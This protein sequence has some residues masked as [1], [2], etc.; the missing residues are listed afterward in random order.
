MKA[1]RKAH[2]REVAP[3]GR[4]RGCLAR[5]PSRRLSRQACWFLCASPVRT[6][7]ASPVPTSVG[8]DGVERSRVASRSAAASAKEF[9]ACFLSGD[10]VHS[11]CDSCGRGT[12]RARHASG[13][14]VPREG[15]Q[16][17]S[18]AG[19]GRM[20]RASGSHGVLGYVLRKLPVVCLA[21]VPIEV[22]NVRLHKTEEHRF[23]RPSQDVRR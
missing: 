11:A 8:V 22:L 20:P 18:V 23:L 12:T 14:P 3:Q 2:R 21:R 15:E 10:L 16:A 19:A 4:L 7:A 13:A 9:T 6:N 1:A 5:W 17:D